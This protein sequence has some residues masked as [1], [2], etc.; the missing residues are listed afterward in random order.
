MDRYYYMTSFTRY[1]MLAI[2]ATFSCL[3]MFVILF[4]T[5]WSNYNLL[6]ASEWLNSF[7]IANLTLI[8]VFLYGAL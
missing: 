7:I 2:P 8:G 5:S 1:F 4:Y 6:G 3:L